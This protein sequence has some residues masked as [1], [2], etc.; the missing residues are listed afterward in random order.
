MLE[1]ERRQI[2]SATAVTAVSHIDRGLLQELSGNPRIE[3]V[4]NGIDPAFYE[5]DA[6]CSEPDTIGFIGALDW[7]PTIDA[8]HHFV[9]HVF[10]RVRAK[11]PGAQLIVAGRRPQVD[12]AARLDALPDVELI[13]DVPDM[14]DVLRRIAVSVVPIRVGS[15]SRIKILE[16][17]AAG[18]PV[19]STSIGAEGLDVEDGVELLLADDAE[20]FAENVAR[21]LESRQ[22]ARDLANR[23]RRFVEDNHAWDR[24]VD[25]L[26]HVWA[27]ALGTKTGHEGG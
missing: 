16:S 2:G 24:I 20:R 15:G 11:R 7:R 17:M 26:D 8:V 23:G 19:V 18:C 9:D 13:A 3:V 22:M 25:R 6:H 4:P 1:F 14:R 27:T 5:I 10:P 21:V 12:L